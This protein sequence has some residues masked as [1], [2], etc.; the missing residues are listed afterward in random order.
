VSP[1]FA[2]VGAALAYAYFDEIPV[3]CGPPDD[4]RSDRRTPHWLRSHGHGH[5][6]SKVPWAKRVAKRR[7]KTRAAKRHKKYLKNLALQKKNRVEA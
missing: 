2:Y 3:P 5:P 7:A 4:T 1:G 6:G